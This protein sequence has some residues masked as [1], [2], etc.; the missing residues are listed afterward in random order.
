MKWPK[1]KE[2]PMDAMTRWIACGRKRTYASRK[3]AHRAAVRARRASGHKNI[4]EYVCP[5]PGADHY[6]IGHEPRV[7]ESTGGN[8]D[9][10]QST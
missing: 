1:R 7:L 10:E 5:V 3:E 2:T 9:N 4:V 6:H 8:S